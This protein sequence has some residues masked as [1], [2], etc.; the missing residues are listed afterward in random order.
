MRKNCWPTVTEFIGFGKEHKL[1][2]IAFP[3]ISTGAFGYP[4]DKALKTAVSVISD[5]LMEHDMMVFL[6]VYDKDS[7]Q[8][9]KSCSIPL[10]N[11]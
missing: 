3:L 5:F 7:F 9:S 1:E 10:S 6:V 11:S 8:L 2:N 4:K